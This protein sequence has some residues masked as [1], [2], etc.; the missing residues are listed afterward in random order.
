LA[1]QEQLQEAVR[2]VLEP[3]QERALPPVLLG[4]AAAQRVQQASQ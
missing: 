1:P 4:R 2:L 3:Q